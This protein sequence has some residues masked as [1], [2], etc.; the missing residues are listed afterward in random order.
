MSL[1][2]QATV[3]AKT[4]HCGLTQSA[5]RVEHGEGL[6]A[7]EH[8]GEATGQECSDEEE[9]VTMSCF[10]QSTRLIHAVKAY[11]ALHSVCSL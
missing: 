10:S 1:I 5:S 6:R 4:L 9:D 3:M 8:G 7:C 2:D 11:M